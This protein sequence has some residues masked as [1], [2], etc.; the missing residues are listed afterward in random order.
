M[1]RI[2][3][4]HNQQSTSAND[5]KENG[6]AA[7]A[8]ARTTKEEDNNDHKEDIYKVVLTSDGNYE[9]ISQE[10]HT[11]Y[12]HATA[13]HLTSGVDQD[14][15]HWHSEDIQLLLKEFSS[16]LSKLQCLH[17]SNFGMHSNSFPISLLNQLLKHTRTRQLKHIQLECV[18]LIGNSYDLE[19][20]A[21]RIKV[22]RALESFRLS[23][24]G[25]STA[26]TSSSMTSS[27]LDGIVTALSSLPSLEHLEIW[28]YADGKLGSLTSDKTLQHLLDKCQTLQSLHME[29]MVLDGQ[30][31][32]GMAQALCH[33][34]SLQ[35]L[36]L[37]LLKHRV[38]KGSLA[39]ADA[40][41][42]NT[43]LQSLE[44]FL[45]NTK[46]GEEDD[47]DEEENHDR[48]NCH[49]DPFLT[50][51]AQVLTH[52]NSTL[53]EVRMHSFQRVTDLEEELFATMLET[54]VALTHLC[55]SD[56]EGPFRPK[57][58]YYLSWNR[59]GRFPARL[60]QMSCQQSALEKCQT[61]QT[62]QHDQAQKN[63]VR[64]PKHRRKIKGSYNNRN[65][66]P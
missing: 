50:Q 19:E 18:S 49:T 26:T 7:A 10:L 6:A 56:Y 23:Y 40:L 48:G 25:F 4:N 32:Q 58:E 22:C 66:P 1:K 53:R 3:D 2:K 43:S 61:Q 24:C 30:Q 55:L 36:D 64:Q 8:S 44:L 29:G 5:N 38:L 37:H 34:S 28:A 14:E 16:S 31:V 45:A 63:S 54:N 20:L 51:L 13:L 39:L 12:R 17:L 52:S 15:P 21:L 65:G 59:R 9:E 47:D 11:H 46:N 42:E 33:H 41:A 60:L 35:K 57:I 27:S 62:Q